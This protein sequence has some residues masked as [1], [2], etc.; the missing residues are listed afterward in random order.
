MKVYSDIQEIYL[1]YENVNRYE[2]KLSLYYYP[3]LLSS[4]GSMHLFLYPLPSPSS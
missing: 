1:E 4:F 2:I 3:L